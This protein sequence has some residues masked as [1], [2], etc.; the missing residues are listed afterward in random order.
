MCLLSEFNK[1]NILLLAINKIFIREII[2]FYDIKK[3]LSCC[4]YAAFEN[5]ITTLKFKRYADAA[6]FYLEN[7]ACLVDEDA[8][9]ELN[10]L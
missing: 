10:G 6:K 4:D 3:D 5:L 7:L 8:Y 9:N 1:Q 2:T